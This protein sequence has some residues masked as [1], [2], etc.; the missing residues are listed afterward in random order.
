MRRMPRIVVALGLASL[1]T[2]LSSEMIYP[3][4]PL[5]LTGTLGAGAV[6]LGLIE[7]IAE[8]V[9]SLL[10]VFS[11]AW[12]DRTARRKP[13]VV[14]GYG[15][16]GVAR[17]LI[18]LATSWVFV[19]AMRFADRIGK[20]LRTAPRDALIANAAAADQRG[21]AFGFQRVMDHT[22]AVLGPLV[23]AALLTFAGFSINAVF[24]LAAIPAALVM[25]VLVVGVREPG[26]AQRPESSGNS[27]LAHYAEL[28]PDF[29]RY[30]IALGV[31]TLGNSTDAFI[32]LRLS[33]AGVPAA[34]VAVLWALHHVV[35]TGASYMGGVL[36]DRFGRKRLVVAGWGV[37]A[38]VYL[39]F[40][41]VAAPIP[42]IATFLAYGL[43]FGLCEPTER[44]WAAE[45]APAHLRGTAF[46]F[47]HGVVGLAALP[48]SLLFGAVW[49][50]FGAPA[51]FGMGAALAGVAAAL[52]MRVREMREDAA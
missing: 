44:A 46:G 51:A 35:K 50:A 47:Y 52:L 2:D 24:L 1:L 6:A 11:G 45:L 15:I 43:Y 14:F 7:G 21:R 49:A 3:L 9:A 16:A 5:F 42:L 28:S 22:G 18:G 27:L 4:L 19:L 48:A 32:L 31:F 17:P 29:K 25:L 12:S 41:M 40:A 13:W 23:A 36:S 30:L 38:L 33:D 34:S 26:A 8:T 10:K 20:G 37:Y 39:A